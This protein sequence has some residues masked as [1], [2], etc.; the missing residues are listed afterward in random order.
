M[1]ME[2]GYSLIEL[3]TVLVFLGLILLF[4]TGDL[5]GAERQRDFENF[6]GEVIR[7]VEICRW[8]ALNEQAYAGISFQRTAGCF[9]ASL[10]LDGNGNGIRTIDMEQG[11]DRRFQGPVRLKRSSADIE[12]GILDSNVPQIP[13]RTGFLGDKQD[14]VKFGRSDIIS[15]SP[16][17]DSSSGTLYLACHSQKQMFAIVV[18]GTTARVSLWKY[19]NLKWQMVGDR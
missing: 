17:G 12:A 16:Y 15:F 7:L 1:K 6:A 14:P 8:K 19:R 18:Y 10:Y 13:P 4:T 3:M 9:Y 2:R 5:R 11:T